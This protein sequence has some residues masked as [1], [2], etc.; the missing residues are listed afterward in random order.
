MSPSPEA[1]SASARE[2]PRFTSFLCSSFF[3]VTVLV[4][5]HNVAMSEQT[6]M[7]NVT[8]AAA[9]RG[10]E[11][12]WTGTAS[13]PQAARAKSAACFTYAAWHAAEGQRC[14][15]DAQRFA[16]CRKRTAGRL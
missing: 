16:R 14:A 4:R 3:H 2:K 1:R 5:A 13:C 11:W 10:H 7:Q 9:L 12:T 8:S 15:E 6:S